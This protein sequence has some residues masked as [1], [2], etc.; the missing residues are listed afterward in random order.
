MRQYVQALRFARPRHTLGGALSFAAEVGMDLD[1]LE[2]RASPETLY[3]GVPSQ[4]MSGFTESSIA[5][6][7]V[8]VVG[9][10]SR[11]P[12]ATVLPLAQLITAVAGVAG[13]IQGF[14]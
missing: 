9:E 8:A 3:L 11:V 13:A 10:S 14:A 7:V 4:G 12:N 5:P 1:T 2:I 6:G